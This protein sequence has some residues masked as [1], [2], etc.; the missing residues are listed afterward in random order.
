MGKIQ[1]VSIAASLVYLVFIIELVRRKKIKESYALLWVGIGLVFFILSIWRAGLEYFAA[2]VGVA[3]PPAALFLVLI[4]AVFLI[5]IQFSIIISEQA[6][7]VKRLSQ[8][9]GLLRMEM[10]EYIEENA[11]KKKK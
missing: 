3:Y 2:L 6:A 1:I 5:L 11:K 10:E 7:D 9:L 4:L 8:E